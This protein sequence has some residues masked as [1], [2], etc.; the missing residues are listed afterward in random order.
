[1][2][3]ERILI[4][5]ENSEAAELLECNLAQE[6]YTVRRGRLSQRLDDTIFAFRPHLVV[7]DLD[8]QDAKTIEFCQRI[9]Q[10][11]E[12]AAPRVIVVGRQ[13]DEN[14]IVEFFS[15]GADEY[16]RKPYVVKELVMRTKAILRR[17][18][19]TA[20]SPG[21]ALLKAG[22]LAVDQRERSIYLEGS[23]L[24]LT[25][26][27]HRILET[28]AQAPGRT[29]SRE[30]LLAA[31]KD[32]QSGGSQPSFRSIDVHILAIRRRLGKWKHLLKTVR[33]VGYVLQPEA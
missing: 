5:E 7:I 8:A 25:N 2:D 27:E 28:L 17:R 1:M 29:F 13:A 10:T 23:E 11:T 15:R 9:K 22:P 18:V 14:T 6:C 33:G 16:V 26:F 20:R 19:V 32:D 24:Q 31:I 30:Q 3:R 12:K 4:L 21:R